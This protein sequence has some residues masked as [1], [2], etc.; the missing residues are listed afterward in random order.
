[1]TGKSFDYLFYGLRVRAD[2]SL[3]GLA[4][5]E[6]DASPDIEVTFAEGD[7][8]AA[9]IAPHEWIARTPPTPGWRAYRPEGTFVRLILAGP[10]HEVEFV[11]GPGGRRAW[12]S[13]TEGVALQEVTSLLTGPILACLLQLRGTTCLHGSVVAMDGRALV[14]LGTTGAG[15]STTALALVQ[16]GATLVSDDLAP[17]DPASHGFVVRYG[18]PALRLRPNSAERLCGTFDDL[19]PLW[20]ESRGW[21]PKR[22]LDLPRQDTTASSRIPVQAIYLLG[23][24][25]SKGTAP[26]VVRESPAA[27]LAILLSQRT[28]SFMHDN[29]SQARDLTFLTGV[30]EKVPVKRLVRPEDLDRLGEVVETVLADFAAHA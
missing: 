28:S 9:P 16:R 11:L 4:A 15:K 22:C 8:S 18:Q 13:W 23:R 26:S 12:V 1:M 20:S 6:P 17:L 7:R 3:P 19:R 10:G 30:V 21:H 5:L 2:R 25:D 14:L 29:E 24:R 27:A